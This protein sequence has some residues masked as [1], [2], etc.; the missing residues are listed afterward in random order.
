MSESD[1]TQDD[2]FDVEV[3]QGR[4]ELPEEADPE[5]LGC[6]NC[7]HANDHFVF[8]CESCGQDLTI[9]Y[10]ES[11]GDGLF[12]SG[13]CFP[14]CR[15]DYALGNR[16]VC[17]Y[18]VPAHSAMPT[19][20]EYYGM[21]RFLV[22]PPDGS[23]ICLIDDEPVSEKQELRDGESLKIGRDSFTF[24]DGQHP[25]GKR[26][27]EEQAGRLAAL[28]LQQGL[29]EIV[30]AEDLERACARAVDTV[31]RL[32]G[33]ARGVFF[34]T[35]TDENGEM[36][37]QQCVTREVHGEHAIVKVD[38]PFR[39]S[40]SLLMESLAHGGTVV[41]ENASRW[42]SKVS[43]SIVNLRLTSIACIPVVY[44]EG[45]NYTTEDCLGVIYTDSFM[46]ARDISDYVSPLLTQLAN[47]LA[48]AIIHWRR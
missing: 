38:E 18:I 39:I 35:D 24:V 17:D 36:E 8:A 27:W 21:E 15:R 40:Q 22:H 45:P 1:I 20:V 26:F 32:T 44:G 10:L 11:Q 16:L 19:W 34:L 4:T 28:I 7:G 41:L 29:V 6:R 31:L 5:H 3:A 30:G 23:G 47:F 25:D 9:A 42:P 43:D 37:L 48:S 33:M 12:P 13:I 14:L 46:P 2:D